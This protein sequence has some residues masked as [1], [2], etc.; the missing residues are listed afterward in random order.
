MGKQMGHRAPPPAARP[1]PGPGSWGCW[2]D[3]RRTLY[4]SPLH[5][6]DGLLERLVDLLGA[7]VEILGGLLHG[8]G[9]S[10]LHRLLDLALAHHDQAGLAGIDGVSQLL[11]L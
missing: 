11:G 3:K 5:F 4:I 7:H 2:R 9:H 6:A 8:L 1:S 10:L